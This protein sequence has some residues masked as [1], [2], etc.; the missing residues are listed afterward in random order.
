MILTNCSSII[1]SIKMIKNN[2]N[3]DCNQYPAITE[4]NYVYLNFDLVGDNQLRSVRQYVNRYL[5][6]YSMDIYNIIS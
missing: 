4:I 2:G 5:Q 3:D 1:Y 6:R